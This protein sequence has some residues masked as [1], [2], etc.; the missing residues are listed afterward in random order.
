M[1][2]KVYSEDSLSEI[3]SLLEKWKNENGRTM[4][5]ILYFDEIFRDGLS[6]DIN[7]NT[8]KNSHFD[9]HVNSTWQ[10]KFHQRINS[11]CC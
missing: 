4:F 7:D 5:P 10:F 1:R 9:F 3:E 2:Y 11:L 6:Y 8:I